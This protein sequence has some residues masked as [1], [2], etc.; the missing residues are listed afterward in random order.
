MAQIDPRSLAPIVSLAATWAVKK[1]LTKAYE[2]RTGEGP[3][4]RQDLS[5]PITTVL[6]WAGITAFT[7]AIIDVLIQRGA[8]RWYRQEE[9]RA[10]AAE[11]QAG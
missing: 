9:I 4:G 10:L 2:K 7:T 11:Q 6:M 5:T 3:P 1:A 8:A